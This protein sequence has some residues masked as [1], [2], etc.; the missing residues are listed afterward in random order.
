MLEGN[1]NIRGLV[2]VIVALLGAS[3]VAMTLSAC[4]SRVRG[5]AKG[6]AASAPAAASAIGAILA[7]DGSGAL[8]ALAAGADPNAVDAYGMSALNYASAFGMEAVAKALLDAG[9]LIDYRDPWGMSSLMAATKEGADAVALLLIGRGARVDIAMEASAYIGFTAL[10]AAVYFG[11]A[12]EAVIQALLAAGA[13]PA[14]KDAKGKTALDYA[15]E[16]GRTDIAAIL[17][18][19]R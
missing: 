3:A 2:F 15:L 14:L 19:K 6:V 17:Q 13:D 7:K 12:G 1:D 11:K 5:E 10:H 16:A 9:A 4:L 8:A 18:A